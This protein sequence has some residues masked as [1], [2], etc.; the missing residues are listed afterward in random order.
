VAVVA[1]ERTAGPNRRSEALATVDGGDPFLEC[2]LGAAECDAGTACS[3]YA[4]GDAFGTRCFEAACALVAQ[5]CGAGQK[6]TFVE[7][8]GAAARAC[9][10]DGEVAE[11]ELCASSPTSNNCRAGLVCVPVRQRDGGTFNQCL[12][13]CERNSDCAP[14]QSCFLTLR[15]NGTTERPLV[16]STSCD[17]F[18]QDCPPGD[19]CYPG[20]NV[21]GCYPEGGAGIGAPCRSS[22]ECV[23]GA[24]CISERCAA[25]CT[26][27]SG[28]PAC[29]IGRCTRLDYPGAPDAGVC[30]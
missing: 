23:K 30:L 2:K 1:C 12:R 28:P 25:I 7:D 29:A 15:F 21:P 27:P 3:L 16:C 18:A 8:G 10:P 22:E 6:C 5:N 17:L 26:Y 24:A 14:G 19:G 20:P 4:R 13:F 9:V 11:G